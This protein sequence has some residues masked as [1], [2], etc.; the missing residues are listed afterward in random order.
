MGNRINEII[1][2]QARGKKRRRPPLRWIG[3]VFGDI[4]EMEVTNWKE[5][6]RDRKDWK[7]VTE[8][9]ISFSNK[10]TNIEEGRVQSSLMKR[11]KCLQRDDETPKAE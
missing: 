9:M 7:T 10:T 11:F 5:M 3:Q 1:E 6:I 4:E 8:K 2:W